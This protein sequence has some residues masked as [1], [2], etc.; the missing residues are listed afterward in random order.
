MN[1]PTVCRSFVAT[2][3]VVAALLPI[4]ASQD[5]LKPF[6][7]NHGVELLQAYGVYVWTAA[8]LIVSHLVVRRGLSAGEAIPDRPST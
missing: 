6:A 3:T 8:L 4:I 1:V 2:A 5:V 7:G